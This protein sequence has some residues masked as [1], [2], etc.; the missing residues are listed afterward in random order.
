M[1]NRDALISRK[2]PENYIAPLLL[3]QT[4]LRRIE[5]HGR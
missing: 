5:T 3:S 1:K 2:K 4:H